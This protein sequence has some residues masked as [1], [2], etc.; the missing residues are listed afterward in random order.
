[1]KQFLAFATICLLVA[2]LSV[3][4]VL[5]FSPPDQ[6]PPSAY[7]QIHAGMSQSEVVSIFGS[8]N[9]AGVNEGDKSKEIGVWQKKVESLTI[10]FD[11]RSVRTVRHDIDR[12]TGCVDRVIAYVRSWLP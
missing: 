4:G 9:I 2:V 5:L 12:Q 3:H 6:G 1:M 11:R 10:H 8:P 7:A